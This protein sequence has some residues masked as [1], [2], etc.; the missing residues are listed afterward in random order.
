MNLTEEGMVALIECESTKDD[1]GWDRTCDEIK[2]RRGGFYPPD[3]FQT[4]LKP[5]MAGSLKI[6]IVE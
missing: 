2:K 6:E 5:R 1:A 3:W 4:V